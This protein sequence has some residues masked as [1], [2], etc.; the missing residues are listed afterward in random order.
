MKIIFQ[1]DQ[2]EKM[3]GMKEGLKPLAPSSWA[4]R[5]MSFCF[6]LFLRREKQG[7]SQRSY[8]VAVSYASVAAL[9]PSP[10]FLASLSFFVSFYG[11]VP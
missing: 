9:L 1:N 5:P 10:D 7:R 8:S 4:L 3:R 2:I 11:W 6:P